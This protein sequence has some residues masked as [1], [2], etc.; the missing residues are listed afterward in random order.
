[1]S[2]R[3]G[4]HESQ[5][6][7]VEV[8][9]QERHRAAAAQQPQQSGRQDGSN[10]GGHYNGKCPAQ[11]LNCY[12][13]QKE[14]HLAKYGRKPKAYGNKSS[15]K[16]KT[17]YT[18]LVPEMSAGQRSAKPTLQV[19]TTIG[20]A[21]Q[22]LT[23]LFDTGAEVCVICPTQLKAF[24]RVNK[25]PTAVKLLAASRTEIQ[26]QGMVE[27]RRSTTT[28]NSTRQTSTWSEVL[29]CQS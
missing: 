29:R 11:G 14:G 28:Q 24:G 15:H 27:A 8:I 3:Q 23:R 13:C 5:G 16:E 9:V 7:H 17:L 2:A 20:K 22:E 12:N 10:C 6:R 1:M 18:V 19:L 25:K 21:T 26:E 4:G